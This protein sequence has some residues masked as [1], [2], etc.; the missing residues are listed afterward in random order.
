VWLLKTDDGS[1]SRCCRITV[2]A[3]CR[4][5]RLPVH[6]SHYGLYSSNMQFNDA[7]YCDDLGLIIVPILIGDPTGVHVDNCS[8]RAKSVSDAYDHGKAPLGHQWILQV[9]CLHALCNLDVSLLP[10]M[11]SMGHVRFAPLQHPYKLQMFSPA[12]TYLCHTT[13]SHPPWARDSPVF[14]RSLVNPRGFLNQRPRPLLKTALGVM[15]TWIPYPHTSGHGQCS[16]M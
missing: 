13:T 4:S 5:G 3:F 8:T 9:H 10:R 6:H 16:T 14:A 12:P 11:N 7:H 1:E 15:R 2:A